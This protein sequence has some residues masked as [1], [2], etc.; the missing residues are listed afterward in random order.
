MTSTRKE[1]VEGIDGTG[2]TMWMVVTVDVETGRWIWTERFTS[3][4]EAECW[5]KWA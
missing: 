2:R 1:M 5:M 4:R 3:K